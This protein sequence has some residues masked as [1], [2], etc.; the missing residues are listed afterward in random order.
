MFKGTSAVAVQCNVERVRGWRVRWNPRLQYRIT[1]DRVDVRAMQRKL[2]QELGGRERREQV[3]VRD[4]YWYEKKR[5]YQDKKFL[6]RKVYIH[7]RYFFFQG[8]L[9]SL[10]PTRNRLTS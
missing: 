9:L 6:I 4:S 1:V 5:K 10:F 8:S 2:Q 7:Y 3:R